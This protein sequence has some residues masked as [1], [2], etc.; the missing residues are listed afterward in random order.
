[1]Q[2]GKNTAVTIDYVLKDDTGNLIDE[3]NDGQFVFL[4][5]ASNIIPGLENAL[6]GKSAGEE[7][8]VSIAPA[9]AYGEH[10]PAR[11]QSVKREMFPEGI[12]IQV[13]AQ[14]HG[15]SPNGDPVV[16]TVTS[17][18]GDDI[19]IDGNHALAG[20]TLNF[21]V[22]V[23]DVRPATEEEISHGH[24]HGPGGHHH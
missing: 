15:A 9:E 18:D 16:V 6:L 20:Q 2:I 24:I 21:A 1:M 23:V 7:L 10:D 3:S 22:K 19:V 13:G 11:V 8:E 14:F 4:A 12:D 17:I 5:G